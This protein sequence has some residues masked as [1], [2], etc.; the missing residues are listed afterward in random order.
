MQAISWIS[1]VHSNISHSINES[2]DMRYSLRP[3][4]VCSNILMH[5]STFEG[6]SQYS[7]TS[8]LELQNDENINTS[9]NSSSATRNDFSNNVPMT[10][11]DQSN[12]INLISSCFKCRVFKIGHINIQG[13]NNKIDQVM[14]LLSSEIIQISGLSKTK[15]Q[16]YHPDAFYEIDGYR[17]TFRRDRK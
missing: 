8:F 1:T 17:T 16:N 15:L 13:M 12:S 14:L 10:P 11:T 7:S 6:K 5:D 9:S 4:I 2:A 3:S